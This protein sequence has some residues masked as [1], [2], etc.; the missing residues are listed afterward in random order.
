MCNR[1][2]SAN[3]YRM[4]ADGANIHQIT[5][6]TLFDRAT[7]I[8]PDGR[9]LYDRWEYVDR[10]FRRCP[11]AVDGQPGRHEPGDLLGQ[12]HAGSGR[13]DRRAAC[14][15]IRTRRCASSPRA[16]ICPGGRWR[17]RSPAGVGRPRAGPAD[18]AGKRDGTGAGS[19]HGQRRVGRLHA[20]APKYKDPIRCAT[21]SSWSRG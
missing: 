6:N 4:E 7:D 14:S 9:I 17:D 11:G 15:R 10:N 3:L 18:L 21:R 13:G 12:Q 1:H 19:G 2:I 16:T 8:L 5:K 20:R